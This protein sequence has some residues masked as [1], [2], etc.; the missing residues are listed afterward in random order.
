[1]SPPRSRIH[2]PRPNRPPTSAK[3]WRRRFAASVSRVANL[4]RPRRR[5]AGPL[6]RRFA[7]AAGVLVYNLKFLRTSAFNRLF[8]GKCIEVGPGLQGIPCSR[9]AARAGLHGVWHSESYASHIRQTRTGRVAV[10]LHVCFE[11]QYSHGHHSTTG[12]ALSCF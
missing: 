7:K 9:C 1:M 8:V 2:P 3:R 12:T 6:R 11:I 10:C 5:S 4:L